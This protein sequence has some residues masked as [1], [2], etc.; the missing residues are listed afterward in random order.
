MSVRVTVRLADA[1]AVLAAADE[2]QRTSTEAESTAIAVKT[3]INADEMADLAE[4]ARR[5]QTARH[6]GVVAFVDYRVTGDCAELHTG[7]AG[8]S[9][10]CWSGTAA[11]IAGVAAAVATT[12]ADLHELG[13]IHGRVDRSHVLMGPDG[14]PKLCGFSPLERSADPADDVAAVGRMLER[15]IEEPGVSSNRRRRPWRLSGGARLAGL[16]GL[17]G[18]L[19]ERRALAQVVAHATDPNP[20]RRPPARGLARSILAAVRAAELPAAAGTRGRQAAANC[21]SAP[22]PQRSDRFDEVFVDQTEVSPEDVFTNRPWLDPSDR[23]LGVHQ[24]ESPST[25]Q[26][27]SGLSRVLVIAATI[28]GVLAVAAV[29]LGLRGAGDGGRPSDGET[30]GAAPEGPLDAASATSDSTVACPP[31]DAEDASSQE[32]L[33]VDISGDG[34]AESVAI[35]DGVITVDGERWV[36]GL[37]GDHLVLGDWTCDG[38]ATPAA[39]RQSTGDVF[40]F[41]DWADDRRPLTVDPVARVEGG[42]SLAAVPRSPNDAHGS[43]DVPAVDMRNGERRMIHVSP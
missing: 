23:H 35:D 41:P 18:L 22:E 28:L 33:R 6:P 24:V 29:A 17:P 42:V 25:P 30:S 11:Q 40:V 31:V 4:E 16:V 32:A 19:A 39:Y 8:E 43:C 36:I 5:L 3:A 9:L 2:P 10:E 20:T 12:L 34:C 27:S 15:M 21:V 1:D 38:V 26:R 37:P 7:Y 13:I 14:R